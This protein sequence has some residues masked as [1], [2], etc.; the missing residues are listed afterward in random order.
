MRLSKNRIIRSD[1]EYRGTHG[2]NAPCYHGYE[3][4]A[5]ALTAVAPAQHVSTNAVR[6]FAIA[7]KL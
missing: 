1:T 6:C 4:F 5:G 3:S 7:L 2:G